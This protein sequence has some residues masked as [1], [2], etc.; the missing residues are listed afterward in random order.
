LITFIHEL[1]VEKTWLPTLSLL[2]SIATKIKAVKIGS[3]GIEIPRITLP[4]VN[5]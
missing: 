2:V 1:K 3:C 5:G 4:N